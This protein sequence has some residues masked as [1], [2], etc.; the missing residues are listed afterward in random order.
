MAEKQRTDVEQALLEQILAEIKQQGTLPES[1]W[2]RAAEM[3][4]QKALFRRA[5]REEERPLTDALAQVGITVCSAWNLDE[6]Q[7]KTA[8]V[9]RILAE[10]LQKPY[11][12]SILDGIVRALDRADSRDEEIRRIL[13]TRFSTIAGATRAKTTLGHVLSELAMPDDLHTLLRYVSDRAHGESRSGLI[14][15]VS[16]LLGKG[17]Y[18]LLKSLLRDPDVQ[19]S[20][21]ESL[22]KLG[23]SDAVSELRPFLDHRDSYVR[24]LAKK[25][26][27]RCERSKPAATSL[28]PEPATIES[29]GAGALYEA[30]SS[31]QEIED[32][33]P[34]LRKLD[35]LL[36]LGLPVSSLVD[37]Y[38][39]LD[40][41]QETG[42]IFEAG[43]G[44]KKVP[45][46]I[47][48]Y[49]EDVDT[50]SVY[51]FTPSAELAQLVRERLA[52]Q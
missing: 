20:V 9:A 31:S 33:A 28:L 37:V 15:G 13:L 1:H 50:C 5:L 47:R 48:F 29:V 8:G 26:I 45:L 49:K 52:P 30:W 46:H 7:A 18:P 36:R 19:N 24:Q 22:G 32:V 17:A 41:G 38:E 51:L 25:A 12:D 4:L 35:R 16:K 34:S 27:K 39:D 44:A 14:G 21:I 23:L 42:F 6:D 11:A 2:Q 3:R 10:H 43:K 40:V